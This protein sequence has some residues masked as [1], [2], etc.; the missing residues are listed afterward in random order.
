MVGDLSLL[1]DYL[2]ETLGLKVKMHPWKQKDALP[3]YILNFYDFYETAL[4]NQQC[5]FV[6]A[7]QVEEITPATIKKHLEIVAQKSDR[8]CIFVQKT[9]TSYNRK[10][11]IERRIPF[12][13][14]GN[15]M[16]LPQSGIDFREYFL[17]R[18][19]LKKYMSPATQVVII[20]A[21]LQGIDN[22]YTPTEL[23]KKLGY[24][25][26]TMSRAFDELETMELGKVSREGKERWLHF[27]GKKSELWKNSKS[28][29]KNP[30]KKRVWVKGRKPKVQAGLSALA[31]VSML[32]PPSIPVHAVCFKDWKKLKLNELPD[33]EG[34][35]FE[36][37]IWHYNPALFVNKGLVDSFSLYLSLQEH[38]DERIEEVLKE[39]MEKVKW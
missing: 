28:L 25:S 14:P 2:Y 13:I 22:R 31:K 11:L 30:V 21:L 16:Y 8:V 37:E 32:V 20:H 38:E 39:E 35:T 6:I 24:T 4:L 19:I 27:E 33:S 9:T 12:I 23:S 29:M 17:K 15:Q 10:R 36:L 26:M 18:K 5:L 1:Y 34:A 7:T 3:F